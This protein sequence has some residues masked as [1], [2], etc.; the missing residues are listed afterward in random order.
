MLE[1]LGGDGT[2]VA[3]R[4]GGQGVVGDAVDEPRHPAR[5][6]E[7]SLNGGGLEQGEFAAG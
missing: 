3:E 6:L 5:A 7:Q 2:G 1:V 4:G